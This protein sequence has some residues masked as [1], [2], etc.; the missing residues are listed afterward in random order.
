VPDV[1]LTRRH[2]DPARVARGL[3][4]D[5]GGVVLFAGRVR[6]DR[7]AAGNVEALFY[8][9]HK[10]LAL[11]ALEDVAR[12]AE[13]KFG[14][15]ASVLHHRLGVVPV[16]ETSVIVAAAAPHRDAAFRGARFL[17]DQLKKRAPIWKSDRVRPA[18]PRPRRPRRRRARSSG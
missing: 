16:G 4:E 13:R 6:P 12:R 17:I 18:R 15:T 5:A 11:R 9:A 14:L 2:L 1:L 10:S 7:V 3:P 8:E